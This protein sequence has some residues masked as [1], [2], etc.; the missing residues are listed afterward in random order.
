MFSL[1]SHTTFSVLLLKVKALKLLK[2]GSGHTPT[3][4]KEDKIIQEKKRERKKERADEKHMSEGELRRELRHRAC[5]GHCG[6]V[7]PWWR[8]GQA[9]RGEEEMKRKEGLSQFQYAVL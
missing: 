1:V 8:G 5:S 4:F 3:Q 2:L 9:R 7:A 6:S